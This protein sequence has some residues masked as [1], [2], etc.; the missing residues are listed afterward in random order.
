ML[1]AS[2]RLCH[3][4][5]MERRQFQLTKQQ[6]A[7]VRREATRRKISDSAIVRE[8]VDLWLRA[9]GHVRSEDRMSRAMG[10]VGKFASGQKDLSRDHDRELADAFRS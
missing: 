9:R 2:W 10:I 8:A 5:G 6:A 3:H 1:T 7:A 4:D